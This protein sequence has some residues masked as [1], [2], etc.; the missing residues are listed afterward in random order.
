M[1]SFADAPIVSLRL[2][3]NLDA[4]SLRTGHDVYFECDVRANPPT[5]RLEWMRNV[6]LK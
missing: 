3:R 1:I 5:L 6:S 4:D 2:G